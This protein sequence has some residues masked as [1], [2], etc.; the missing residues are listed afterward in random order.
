MNVFVFPLTVLLF[1][2][3]PLTIVAQSTGAFGAAAGLAAGAALGANAAQNSNT[4]ASAGAAN[5]PIEMNIMVYGGVKKIASDLADVVAS[6]LAGKS[7]HTP[8]AN[9]HSVEP[10]NACQS[11]GGV[12]LEDSTTMPLI[13]LH[14]SWDS[15]AGALLSELNSIA[16]TDDDAGEEIAATQEALQRRIDEAQGPVP[17]GGP[18]TQPNGAP[19]GGKLAAPAPA[20][21]TATTGTTSGSGSGSSTTPIGL[22]YLS[23]LGTAL[24]TFKSG[25]T[26]SPSS[27]SPASQALATALARD[28]CTKHILLYTSASTINLDESANTVT[29]QILRLESI[30]SHIQGQVTLDASVPAA[31][32]DKAKA[33]SDLQAAIT[34]A[35]KLIKS[36]SGTITSNSAIANQL[37]GAFLSWQ[38]GSDGNGGI[39]LTDVIRAE[40]ITQAMNEHI[41]ALQV[42]I[43]AAG[44]NTRTNSYFLLNLFYTPK[45]SFN[46]GVVVTYELRDENNN[47][48]AGDTLKRLY[49]YSKWNPSC[50]EMTVHEVDDTTLGMGDDSNGSRKRRVACETRSN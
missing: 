9:G 37:L 12:L 32:T 38:A 3:V 19:S 28:L 42:N 33:D 17:A 20:S 29:S 4:P 43:D 27:V 48:L 31:T 36:L 34:Q 10:P 16:A 50:F 49:D 46:A 1:P 23:D 24:S 11:T 15:M 5:A 44:G 35:S 7:M 26:Y 21:S 6:K 25:L 40:A 30:N 39:V 41:P 8:N 2:I 13:S 45:P 18:V 22:T 47:F 14:A